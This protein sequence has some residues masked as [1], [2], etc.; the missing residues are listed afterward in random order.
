MGIQG[1]IPK[2]RFCSRVKIL[3]LCGYATA[4]LSAQAEM[5]FNVNALHLEENQKAQTDLSLLSRTDIQIPGEYDVQVRVNKTRVGE[6]HL[7]FVVCDGR[8]LCP[9][10]TPS[11]LR[12]LGV[13][14]QVFPAIVAMVADAPIV[15]LGDY[16]RGANSDFDF[17]RRILNLSIP[18]AAL[19]NRARGDV[20]PEQWDSGVP[21]LFASY[22]ATGSEV[23]NHRNGQQTS[24]QYLSLRS[25]ANLGEWRVRNYSYYTRTRQGRASWNSMQTWV[26]R[27]I[28]SLRARLVTG[29]TSS[30]GLVF[31]SFSFRGASLSTQSE[32]QPDSLR[33]YAP[34]IRG[35]AITNATVEIRQNGNLLYQTF[36]SPG[37][38]VI[39]DLYATSTSGELVVTI[40]EEDGEI[41]TFTQSF[42]SP[43]IS[44]RKGVV[45]YSVTAG[46][47]GTRYYNDSSNAVSQRFAQAEI[48]YGLLNSTSV[49]G[50]IIV[51]EHYHSGMLGMGQSLGRLG[52]VSLDVTHAES[53]FSDGTIRSGQSLQAKYSK[54]FDITGTSMTLAGYRYATDGFFSFDEASN[55]YHSSSLASRYS[56][57]SK[58]QLTLSQNIGWLG[59]VS[60]SAYQSEYWNRGNSK[61]RSITGSWSKTFDGISV[62]LNQSQS[63]IW[64]TEKTDNITS[65]SLSLPLGKWLSSSGSSVRMTN[66]WS[67][68]DQGTSSLTSTL[69]GTALPGNNL[70]WSVSQAQSRSSAGSATDSTAI[71]GSYRGGRATAGLGYSNYYG[72]R[73][74]VSWNLR[75]S[76]VAHPYGITL[77]Q[78]LSEGA[79]YALV[80]APAA[81][82][83]KIR[84]RTGLVTDWRGY[85]VVPSLTAYRDNNVSLDTFTL[86][87]N[88][89]VTDPIVHKVPQKEAMVL[90]DYRTRV[91]YR[92][93]LTLTHDGKPLP[94]GASVSAGEAAGMSNEQG[95][96]WLTGMKANGVIKATLAGG[97][98]CQA[99]FR[100]DQ[101]ETR[102]GIKMVT[103]ECRS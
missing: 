54:H 52:A 50:G 100:V 53:T 44:V 87:D 25:G 47:Y 93:F 5:Y 39:N 86:P 75:G 73:E 1:V 103:L 76:V 80:R 14:I 58:A 13:K 2:Y 26:E 40:K 96:I 19:D 49:Y 55:Y 15:K 22:S 4:S 42:A 69:S 21:M 60:F 56:L 20:P 36:V 79:G 41:R 78:Q 89:D 99:P 74:T 37:A 64:R 91:G 72:L 48:L 35:V 10:L 24:T 17:D 68:S 101:A 102:N 92:V 43:P 45:K 71:S 98:E 70:S 57:K 23:K 77:S 29:E 90:A 84:N 94:L 6:H 61:T 62:S 66:S 28:R 59:S 81:E 46:E 88:V 95:Q 32:M 33:G 7:R 63:R 67:R 18:Q 51:A 9:Q 16:I 11:L 3:V 30:P 31:D 8:R 82:G 27:D 12:E 85:A 65:V 34:E 97:R 83:V 38:F